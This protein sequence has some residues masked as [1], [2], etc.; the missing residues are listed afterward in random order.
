MITSPST[1]AS[2]SWASPAGWHGGRVGLGSQLQG[3]LCPRN[4]EKES[5]KNIGVDVPEKNKNSAYNNSVDIDKVD[6]YC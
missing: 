5:G 3:A 2:S 1:F 4:I 6:I